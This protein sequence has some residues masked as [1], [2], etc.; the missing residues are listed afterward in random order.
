MGL[1]ANGIPHPTMGYELFTSS[2][3]GTGLAGGQYYEVDG[4]FRIGDVHRPV[5][6]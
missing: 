6:G 5:W 2:L 4:S 1:T 3:S